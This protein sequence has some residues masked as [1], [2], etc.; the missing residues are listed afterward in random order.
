MAGDADLA[1]QIEQVVDLWGRQLDAVEAQDFAKVDTEIDW[2]IKRKLFQRYQ[3]RYG[4]EL[5]DPKI[6]QLDLAYHDIKRGRGVFDL[7]QRK[8][9]AARVTTDEE[10]ESAVDVPPQTTRA[11][12]R[13]EFIAAAQEAGRDFTVDWVHLKLNDQSQRSGGRIRGLAI[14]VP[15]VEA[16]GTPRIGRFGWKNQHASLLSFSG[17][18]YLNEMGITNLV[19]GHGDFATDPLCQG[20]GQPLETPGQRVVVQGVA[21]VGTSLD[22]LAPALAFGG[23]SKGSSWGSRSGISIDSS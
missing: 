7:L 5:S 9:L 16:G 10:I 12:L 8:G 19:R 3:D 6:S 4:M 23:S 17:D 20:G 2:V 1:A 11:K 21:R 14:Q 13:G 22:L 18:A 15:V